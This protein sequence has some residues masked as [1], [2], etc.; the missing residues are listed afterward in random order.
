VAF[1]LDF[2][3]NPF[4]FDSAADMPP[5]TV[6][7][8]L[9]GKHVEV[10]L[11]DSQFVALTSLLIDSGFLVTNKVE[12]RVDLIGFSDGTAWSGQMV[13]RRPTGGWMPLK[14]VH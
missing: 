2:G 1:D 4:A 11:S 5:V 12:I 14:D 7:P 6:K 3:D 8:V 9:P 10:A 13:Q